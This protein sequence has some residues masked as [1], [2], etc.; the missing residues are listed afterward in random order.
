MS[1]RPAVLKGWPDARGIDAAVAAGADVLG[2]AF[3]YPLALL[4]DAA[5]D[6]NVAAMAAYCT[7]QDVLLAPHAK[8]TMAPA[9]CRRQLDAGAWGLTV[10]T[11]A[12][13][14]TMWEAG[15]HRLVLANPL[16]GAGE[17]AWAATSAGDGEIVSFADDVDAVRR[18]DA[19]VAAAAPGA[20]L[21]VLVEVG[22]AG[23]RC[24][25][26]SVAA[27]VELASEIAALP[28]LELA[29][30]AGFEGLLAAGAEP[31]ELARVAGY[32]A[33][34]AEAA[35]AIAARGLFGA[36][37]PLL[38]AGGS[39]FFD[40]AVDALAPTAR[41]LGGRVLLRSGCYVTHDHGIYARTGPSGGRAPIAP[42]EPAL[43]VWGLVL[44]RPEPGR[45][46]AGVGKRDVAFDMGLPQPVAWRRGDGP[47]Q[48]APDVTT[49]ALN[50]QHAHLVLAA[51]AD[52][53]PGDLIGF[54]I[55]HPCAAFD[56]W[57]SL[58]L[59][60][61]RYRLRGEIATSF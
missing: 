20:C 61:E 13:A 17:I 3:R 11:W 44:S 45:A 14:Q 27:A 50:D 29:G 34:I 8:T 59:V 22:Y 23:G 60:D 6:R 55:S 42:F 5:I 31:S 16:V 15:F 28:H 2:G 39:S 24:G 37:P 46:I 9:L 35:E 1:E 51:D 54:G 41:A 40:L 25:V 53:R 48:A 7:A 47:V 49:D 52:L 38:S 21:P 33:A 43:E 4:K 57:R 32:L 10:A 26:R 12:Q 58:A 56:R 30:V 19:G 36:R 18:L